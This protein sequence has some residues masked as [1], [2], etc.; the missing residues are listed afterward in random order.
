[1]CYIVSLELVKADEMKCQTTDDVNHILTYL[2]L[3]VSA[4]YCVWYHSD[5]VKELLDLGTGYTSS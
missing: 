2:S 1:M 5:S 3:S 4:V